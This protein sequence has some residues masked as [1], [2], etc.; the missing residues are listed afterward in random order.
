MNERLRRM[1][2]SSMVFRGLGYILGSIAIGAVIA[3][4]FIAFLGV[5]SRVTFGSMLG[6]AVIAFI[7]GA[8]NGLLCGVCTVGFVANRPLV[9]VFAWIGGLCF[10]FA[11]VLGLS[12]GLV[13]DGSALIAVYVSTTLAFF[14]AVAVSRTRLRRVGVE[15]CCAACGYSL[16]GLAGL[17]CPECGGD[18]RPS[19]TPSEEAT[20]ASRAAL[21]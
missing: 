10:P 20:A 5:T 9:K 17:V 14:V 6:A 4:T 11:I 15:G 16:V 2:M 19:V 12:G 3:S 13:S 21:G 1:A 18:V 8:A 7:V